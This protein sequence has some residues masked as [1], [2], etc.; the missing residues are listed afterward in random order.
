MPQFKSSTL[1]FPCAIHYETIVGA[2]GKSPSPITL[3]RDGLVRNDWRRD[4]SGYLDA[5]RASRATHRRT[6][7]GVRSSRYQ[8]DTAM[9]RRT[10]HRRAIKIHLAGAGYKPHNRAA[11]EGVR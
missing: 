4:S 1:K 8:G 9:I 6:V 5:E 3:T 7:Y 11:G 10:I 2:R